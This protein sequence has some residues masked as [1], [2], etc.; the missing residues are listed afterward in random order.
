MEL[1]VWE[2]L[3]CCVPPT[4]AVH[5]PSFECVQR[6]GLSACIPP[7][8]FPLVRICHPAPV[9]GAQLPHPLQRTSACP[10]SS[11]AA[12][13]LVIYIGLLVIWPR[14]PSPYATVRPTRTPAE[15][16]GSRPTTRARAALDARC[17][18]KEPHSPSGS[19][20]KPHVWCHETQSR[21]VRV[22]ATSG[23]RD[24][25]P[26]RS[27]RT[28]S[29]TPCRDRL[30]ARWWRGLFAAAVRPDTLDVAPRGRDASSATRGGCR[31]PTILSMM[32]RARVSDR[33]DRRSAA[34][35]LTACD[36]LVVTVVQLPTLTAPPS[37]RS[38]SGASVQPLTGY[39]GCS[40]MVPLPHTSLVLG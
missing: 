6:A 2:P 15:V 28:L 16:G 35:V 3:F 25:I 4:S 13:F 21:R 40:N 5:R 19:M 36:V 18:A 17:L 34:V 31:A 8:F 23:P 24:A 9:S 7:L 30:K 33:G 37:A 12:L 27:P 29:R 11:L 1:H 22:G 26:S 38:R 20:V 14:T 32:T 39:Y 10:P